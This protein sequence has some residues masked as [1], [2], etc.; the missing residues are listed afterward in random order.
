MD[1]KAPREPRKDMQIPIGDDKHS[2][3]T[4]MEKDKDGHY[5]RKVKVVKK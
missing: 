1:K 2:I 5:Y 3:I 4:Y